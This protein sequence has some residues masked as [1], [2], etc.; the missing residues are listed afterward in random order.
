MRWQNDYCTDNKIISSHDCISTEL[1]VAEEDSE[2]F[3]I[4]L[5]A[6][7]VRRP[8]KCKEEWC[9]V[10]PE[11]AGMGKRGAKTFLI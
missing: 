11:G 6:H 3:S 2:G 9:A 4:D 5:I 10:L 7:Y 8:A 1:S